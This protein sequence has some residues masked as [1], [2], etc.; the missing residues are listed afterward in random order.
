[1]I[2][3]EEYKKL[4]ESIGGIT[5]SDIVYAKNELK[6]FLED[7]GSDEEEP[8][9][10]LK[11][12]FNDVDYLIGVTHKVKNE[13]EFEY[14]Y[15][16]MYI[17]NLEGKQWKDIKSFLENQITYDKDNFDKTYGIF[18]FVGVYG[19]YSIR[20]QLIKTADDIIYNIKD[21]T[22]IYKNQ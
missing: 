19:E 2:E 22:E 20:G 14:K 10:Y 6:T 1:M 5:K 3:F 16:L 18:D 9:S 17:E 11:L 7:I 4:V 8:V 12:N 15:W 13:F 21:D